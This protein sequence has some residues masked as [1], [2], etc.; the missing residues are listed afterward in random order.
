M[1][2]FLKSSISIFLLLVALSKQGSAQSCIIPSINAQ[3]GTGASTTVCS[4]QCAA[5]TA[6]MVAPP[7]STTTYSVGSVTYSTMP[8]F[9]G[10]NVFSTSSDDLWSDSISIGFNFCYFG[11]TYNK[12]LVGSNGEITFDLTRANAP[13]SWVTTAILPNAIEHPGNTICGA[14]RDYDPLPGGV[15]RTYTSGVAPCRQFVAYWSGVTLFSCSTPVSSFQIILYEGSNNIAV[16][17][18]NSTAC[19]AW[20]NG[21][22]LIG[23]QNQAATTV[24]APATRNTLTAWTAINESWLFVPTAPPSFSVNWS[25][26]GGFTA[27]GLT[28]TPCPTTSGTYSATL[29]YCNGS[30]TSTVNV[31]VSTPTVTASASSNTICPPGSVTLTAGGATTYTWMPGSLTGGTVVVSPTVNTTYTVIGSAGTCTSSATVAITVGTPPTINAFNLTGT[32]CPPASANCIAT[33]ALSYTWNP[34]NI[35][36]NIVALSPTV[37]TTYTISGSSGGCIGTATLSVPVGSSPTITALSSPTSICVGSS[38]TLTASGATNYTWMPGSLS[39]ASVS[40]NP[41]ATTIYTVTG[42]NTLT[43]PGTK[44]V[45]LTVNTTPTITAVSN[46]T[47]ICAGSSATLTSSGATSYTWMPGSLSGGTVTVSPATTTIYT[48]TGSNGTCS[49]TRTVQT[50][51]NTIPTVTAAISASSVCAGT[52]VTLTAGGATTYTWNPGGLTG[53]TVVTTPTANTTYTVIGSNGTCTNSANV[54][55]TVNPSPTL[56][57]VANPTSICSGAGTT[58]TL[59]ST[60]AASYTWMP[61]S[62]SGGTVTANPIIT[63]TYTV[64]GASAAGCTNTR[65]VTLTVT[66]TPTITASASSATVCSGS[67]VTLSSSGATTYTWNPG[68]LA[69]GTVVVTPTATTIY[70]VTGANGSCTNTR[71]VSITVNPSP[72]VTAVANPTSICSGASATLTGGGATTYTWMPGSIT[73]ATTIVTPTVTTTYTLTGNNGTCSNT[74]TVTLTVTATPTIT[75]ASNPTAICAGASATLTSSGATSYT[76]NPGSVIGGTIAVT[77]TVTTVYTVT[78]ANGSCITTNTVSLTVNSSPTITAIAN[79]TAICAGNSSTLTGSGATTYTW[80]PGSLSGATVAVTPTTTTTYTLTGNNGTCSGTV[81][82]SLSVTPLPT[83]TAVSNPTAICIGGTATLTGGG[84]TSYTWNPGSLTGSTVAVSPTITTI[85]TVTGSNGTCSN[86]RTV[87]LTVNPSPT[88]TASASSTSICA[89]TSATLT[90]N[91]GAT[92]TWMPGSLSGATVVVSPTVTTTYTVTGATVT[93]C[94]NTNTVTINII[95]GPTVTAIASPTAICVGQ[96][97]TLT[98]GGAVTYTW[99]PGNMVSPNVVVSP[100]VTTTYTLTGANASSCTSTVTLLLTVNPIPTISIVA[101]PTTICSGASATLT[102]S[103]AVGTYSWLPGPVLG[104]PI[105]VNPTVTT[106][107]TVRG[108]NAL[109]CISNATISLSVT[110]T[111]TV[112]ASVS[113]PSVCSGSTITLSSS[114]A[115]TYTWNPGA[116][117]GGTITI[118]PT[119][120][121]TYTVTGANGLCTATNTVLVSVTPGPT[122]TAIASPTTICSG[123]S[124][125]L[126]GSGAAT[127]TWMPGSITTAT[128]VVTPTTTTIYTLTGN[129]GTCS[130]TI[131]VTVSVTPLPT[132]SA[133]SS[134]TSICA[135]NTATLTGS[136]ATTYTWMPGSLTTAT[137]AVSPTVTTI[138]T[139]TGANGT[140]TNTQTISLTV[141]ASPTVIATINPVSATICAGRTATLSASGALTYTWMPGAMVSPNVLVSPPTTTTYTLGG[142]N[143]SGCIGFFTITVTVNPNPTIAIV[144]TPTALCSGQSSTLTASGAVGTYSWLPGPIL[145]NPIVVTP[146]VTSTYTVR[147]ANALGCVSNSTIS[148]SVTTTPTV[149]AST[150]AATICAS[151]TVTL[152][153]SGAT[154]YTWMPGS[155]SGG[156]VT[157]SPTV[158][159]TYIVTGA[160][161]NCTNSNTVL[162]TVNPSPTITAVSSPTAICSG[163]SATLTGTGATSYTWMP[164]SITTATTVVTPTTTTIYTL[165]GSNG[166]CSSTVAVTLSVTTTPTLTALANP[167][168]ICAGSSATLTGSGATSYTWMPGSITTASTIVT[169]TATT[170]YTLTGANGVCTNTQTVSLTVNPIPTVTAVSNP[171][172]ICAGNSATL[173]GSGATTY[174]W[175][176]GSLTGTSVVVSPTI[177]TT[178]TV[179][180]SAAGCSNSNTVSIT[181]FSAPSVT[182]LTSKTVICLGDTATLSATGAISYTWNPGALIGSPVIVSPTSTTIYTVTGSNGICWTNATVSIV[183]NTYPVLPTTLTPTSLCAGSTATMIASGAT[184]YTW[185]PGSLS[186]TLVTV[187]PTLTTTY[188]LTG[189]NGNCTSTT[190][191]GITVN[192][193]P[194]I[195][196]VSSPTAICAGSSATL[197]GGGAVSY[198]WMPGSL[199]GTSVVVTPTISTQYTVTGS[200]GICSGT[201]TVNLLVLASPTITAIANPTTMCTGQTA[202][203]TSTGALTYTWMPIAVT[204]SAV[205]VSPTITTTYSVTGIN[206]TGCTKTQT[207][208]LVV[209]TSPTVTANTTSTVL[210][211]GSSATLTSSGAT[212]Y[213]WN[214]GSLTGATVVVT[215]TANTTYTVVGANGSCTDTKTVSITVNPSPTITTVASPTILC[216]GGTS[217]LTAT[218]A[219]SY[220]WMPPAIT[221]SQVV[222]SPT[223]ITVY[224][225]T[226]VNSFGCTK[227]STVLVNVNTPTITTIATP[228]SIC[229]GSTATITA[230]GAATYTWLPS[231][232]TG[233]SVV[234]SPTVTTTYTVIGINTFGCAGATTINLNVSPIP[235]VSAVSSS[236]AVCAGN[237]ATLTGSGATTYTWMPGSLTG[238]NVIVT[239]TATTV[240]TVTGSNGACTNSNTI[241]LTVNPTPTVTG[242]ASPSIMCSGATSTLSALGA[243]SYTWFPGGIASF[244]LAV[245]PSVTTTYTVSGTDAQGCTG[246]GTLQVTINDPTVTATSTPTSLCIGSTATLT[247]SGASTYT[248]NPGAT[249]SS[250]LV[251]TPTVTTTYSVTGTNTMGCQGK[252]TLLLTVFVNPTVTAAA[253]ATTIC[254]GL[255]TT[256]TTSG[257]LTYTWLPGNMTTAT[258]VVTPTTSTTYSV[259]GVNGVCAADTATITINVLQS[260]QNVTATNSGTLTCLTTSVDLFGSTTSTNVVY[261]WSGPSSYTST[262]QNPT[263]ITVGGVYTLSVIDLANGCITTATTAIITNTAGP[264]VSLTSTG[265]ITCI[266]N[267]VNISVSSTVAA[268]TYTWSGPSS[269]TSTATSFSTSVGGVY[270]V[271]AF[272]PASNCTSTNTVAATTDTFVAITATIIPA[273]CTGTVT[274]NNGTILVSNF[275][276]PSDK[277]DFVTGLT[278]TGSATYATATIIPATGTITTALGNPLVNTPYT[279][280]FFGANGCTKDTTLVLI[281]I[282]CSVN[283]SLGLAKAITAVTTNT[284]GTY[285]VTYKVVVKNTGFA[286]LNN[287]MLT[288]NLSNTFPLPTTFTVSSAPVI[289]TPVTSLTLDATFDGSTQPVLTNTVTSS[290]AIGEVDTIVFTVD[291]LPNGVF[292]TFNNSVLG[293]AIGGAAST[294]VADSSQVGLNTDPDNDGNPTNNNV[295]TPLNLTPNTFFGVT[296]EGELSQVLIDGSYDITYTVSI[297][298]LGNDTLRNIVLKDSLAGTTIK[299]PASYSIKSGPSMLS[300]TLT[301]NSAFNGNS[302]PNLIV[303]AG[304]KMAPNT[305]NKVVFSINVIPDT[306][307]VIRN[308][309]IGSA[310]G[311]STVAVRDSSN[312][313]N[314]PDVNGNGVWNEPSDNVPTVLII[315][316]FLVPEVFTPNGDGVNDFFVIKGI[317]KTEN[318]LTIYNRWGNKVYKMDNY[319]NTWGGMPNVSGTLGNQKLPQGTYYYILEFKGETSLK[320]VNG[321]VVLQY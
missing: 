83:V 121:T 130:S 74:K 240:Y 145:G 34:G 288:E 308:T 244:M 114:G 93:G 156:T 69:G 251:V 61:G 8:Y 5:L 118:T 89:G 128:T 277:Y 84:A 275:T 70:T 233:T 246:T 247:A 29:S 231:A 90:A 106:T 47:S 2:N 243:V 204:G 119:I 253:A 188:T 16:N 291:V 305:V 183:V 9:G 110:P 134:P 78:G 63:T 133:V 162:V 55:V 179:T 117:V 155:L 249:A 13:E 20:N 284:N 48:V 140:C 103:G 107:Y 269:F 87:S 170:I 208:T 94:T 37:T 197:T 222:V 96:T 125:T 40:V 281:P 200:N 147:G 207:V 143:A 97:S 267:T 212:T 174:T 157:A 283:N 98:A 109:G 66:T 317:Q 296:K 123:S 19:M 287:V 232:T 201:K 166:T 24:V 205:I 278:Y 163:S 264:T 108:A 206:A 18:Q 178:Y 282:D 218:G 315:D 173:T 71:T 86:T 65:T 192:S 274:D 1:T 286:T 148:L 310:F 17:I 31:N 250:S 115:T 266:S 50:T 91:G 45:M 149:T 42:T 228:T 144:A 300:G 236:T 312:N 195:T 220:T 290:L 127:Y 257:A 180:G 124:S 28:A 255:S 213:T 304:S 51:V 181:V 95:S 238:T 11:N 295:P 273:T 193:T 224:T 182:A 189:A 203:L 25:G 229:V 135:G 196:A 319:D 314:N 60:G 256:L 321:F 92:Y 311:S 252:T 122:L 75:A 298:N 85:Y 215:P 271:S 186:G 67:T 260:P 235:T 3:A 202:T 73:T 307:T 248:W 88:V 272:D 187:S 276:N 254:S 4:G 116:L 280:R 237:S 270:T 318:T 49:S 263:G 169:P 171:T 177:N 136:G 113:S 301:A 217:T 223:V 33:G 293:T 313:G 294:V 262:T 26:P 53:V 139:I 46:P 175:M 219:T 82:V 80:M 303:T 101:S 7:R 77:P 316:K 309:A 211:S 292:G 198:T 190:T 43:C 15:V 6:T 226:G 259:I 176:P 137:I 151:N 172:S 27:T 30:R 102:A 153:S 99:M 23:I 129:N 168:T 152:S 185:M 210:C 141:N 81:A 105:V 191:I 225:V 160:N 32:I 120:T 285:G 12:L 289:I 261:Q 52:S 199:T 265:T 138:Y 79:P 59:T 44:T 72:T 35:V 184:T 104:N 10:N 241:S 320:T 279:I 41:I 150:S 142:T 58:V 158:T 57:A 242:I 159:T 214:P 54:S 38:A 194:T 297:H 14:Y 258:V 100:T 146:T 302:D 112:T 306:V 230:S 245:T 165:T 111:P 227:T 234:V 56:T 161:G 154:T 68:A 209:N 216:A 64:T 36:G 62:L 22:G 299:N 132:V 39:G 21:R 239:P 131:A 167:T 268:V 126:T 76:W 164:G 221:G